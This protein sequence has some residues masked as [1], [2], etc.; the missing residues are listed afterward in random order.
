MDA[1]AFKKAGTLELGVE[2]DPIPRLLVRVLD[3][4]GDA[5]TCFGHRRTNIWWYTCRGHPGSSG[6]YSSGNHPK[7]RLFSKDIKDAWSPGEKTP[8]EL[9]M[10]EGPE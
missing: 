10:E 7:N 1:R 3:G 8:S 9:R 6:L 5:L 2:D 4:R